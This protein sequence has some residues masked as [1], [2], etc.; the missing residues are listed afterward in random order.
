M[1]ICAADIFISIIKPVKKEST[2]KIKKKINV[3]LLVQII[4]EK[5]Y[6]IIY[7]NKIYKTI[8]GQ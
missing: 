2:T 5:A 4:S 7:Y 8:C 1:D 6:N 3:K